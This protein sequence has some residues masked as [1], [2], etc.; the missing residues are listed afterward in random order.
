VDAPEVI[1][2]ETAL[3]S[4]KWGQNLITS[5][6]VQSMIPRGAILYWLLHGLIVAEF[7]AI[8]SVQLIEYGCCP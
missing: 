3:F 7:E 5:L 2:S 8:A 6:S 4:E 1:E